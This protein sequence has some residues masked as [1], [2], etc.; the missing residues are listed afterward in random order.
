VGWRLGPL[1]ADAPVLA[2]AL[3]DQLCSEREGPVLIDAPE[4]NPRAHRLLAERGFAIAGRTVRMYRGTPPQL[5]LQDIYGL[6][7]LEL[8]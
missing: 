4:A 7:C 1:L 2:G 3:L 6:A 8:G 5:P